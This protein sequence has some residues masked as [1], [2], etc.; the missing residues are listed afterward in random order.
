V[1]EHE[2]RAPLTIHVIAPAP[3]PQALPPPELAPP[4]ILVLGVREAAPRPK[5]GQTELIALVKG[6]VRFRTPGG[7]PTLLGG[8]MV[9]PNGTVVDAVD[10][11]VKVTV[12]HS[13]GGTLDSVDAWGGTFQM[14]QQGKSGITTLTL[15]GPVV[16]A[17]RL[18][19]AAKASVKQSLWVNGKGNFKTR[20]KRASAIVRG[21]YWLTEET[22]AG[23]RVQVTSGLVAVRDF[24]TKATVLVSTGHSYVAKPRRA[25]LRRIPAFT[26]SH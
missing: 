3:Q 10:G 26:G 7:T 15:T 12:E 14:T 20:G 6:T 24:V 2:G 19:S 5:F 8:P 4:E 1:D 22:A 18:A 23:T 11:V 9:V 17:R 25:T 16:A 21:T 13:A